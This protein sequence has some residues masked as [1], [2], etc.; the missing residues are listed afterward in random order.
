MLSML[1]RQ[2]WLPI[3]QHNLDKAE[4]DASI[5]ALNDLAL[6]NSDD[7]LLTQA[8]VVNQIDIHCR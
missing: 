4:I 5:D 2:H 3:T 7:I 8:L 6:D 1:L